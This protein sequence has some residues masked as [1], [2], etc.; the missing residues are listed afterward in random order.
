M[1][2]SVLGRRG[3]SS[4]NTVGGWWWEGAVPGTVVFEQKSVSLGKTLWWW[5]DG[6][7]NECSNYEEN[8]SKD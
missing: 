8:K 7:I 1:E 5:R 4:L 6:V 3:E 2:F